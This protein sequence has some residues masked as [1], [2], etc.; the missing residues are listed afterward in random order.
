MKEKGEPHRHPLLK[1]TIKS[2]QQLMRKLYGTL[3]DISELSIY[4]NP[5]I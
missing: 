3:R 1:R 5:L 2:V 4:I